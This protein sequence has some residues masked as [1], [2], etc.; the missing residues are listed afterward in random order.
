MPGLLQAET[1]LVVPSHTTH[2]ARG[3]KPNNV[4][5]IK[6][7]VRVVQSVEIL[8]AWK[9][10]TSLAWEFQLSPPQAVIQCTAA[11]GVRGRRCA[12]WEDGGR[13][14]IFVY[15]QATDHPK[16]QPVLA[17]MQDPRPESWESKDLGW[18]SMSNS[19]EGRLWHKIAT[20]CITVDTVVMYTVMTWHL[21]G[22]N[23]DSDKKKY[24]ISFI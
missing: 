18:I 14:M 13:W 22:R 21:L 5:N 10:W 8:S 6:S 20:H 19:V 24:A 16:L 12:V 2:A 17:E 9:A 11:H 1:N 15:W 23:I 3:Q 7:R 4:P